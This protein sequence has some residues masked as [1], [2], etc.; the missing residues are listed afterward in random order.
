MLWTCLN[1]ISHENWIASYN[2]I[3]QG[4]GCFFC[5]DRI[6][7]IGQFIHPILEYYSLKFLVGLYNYTVSCENQFIQ[8][9][10][11]RPDLIIERND[12]FKNHLERFQCIINF[13]EEIK[14]ISIDFTFGLN[15]DGILKKF[16]KQYHGNS[17]FLLIVML[18]EDRFC[19]IDV[20]NN[21]ILNEINIHYSEHIRAINYSNFLD[22]LGIFRL[23]NNIDDFCLPDNERKI[24]RSKRKI[25]N[26][27]K[28]I[29]KLAL[30]SIE[31]DSR[32]KILKD[33]YSHFSDKINEYDRDN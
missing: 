6:K 24:E 25:L 23:E 12:Q 4:S 32:L 31:S 13:P 17:Q 3:K 33:K 15:I 19:N 14:S 22:F 5:G 27:F 7:I 2:S 18:R 30:E 16:N 9:R 28:K 1:N 10:Q 11:L 20:I 26:V 29:K 8:D 21:L